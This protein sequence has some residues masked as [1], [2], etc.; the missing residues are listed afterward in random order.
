M[1]SG[2]DESSI[3]GDPEGR[4]LARHR[5]DLLAEANRISRALRVLIARADAPTDLIDA[6]VQELDKRET[7]ELLRAHGRIEPRGRYNT[8][9]PHPLLDGR[10]SCTLFV[11][12]SGRS[13][14]GSPGTASVFALAGILLD[15]DKI[16]EYRTQA[17]EIK[18]E[19]FGRTNFSFH[20][21]H[22]RNRTQDSK[23]RI[24]YS[25]SRNEARQLAFDAA[26]ENLI[27]STPFTAVGIGIRKDV[28]VR[29]FV[30]AGLDPYLPVKAYPLAVV[31]LLERLIDYLASS[32]P[33]RMARVIFESQGAREDAEHQLEYARILLE[34]SQWVPQR[35]FQYYLRTGLGFAPK[36]QSD[37]AEL[38]DFFS[39]DVFEWT[40]SGCI[41]EPKWWRAFCPKL[42]VRGDGGRGKFSL[43]VFPD[44]DIREQILAHRRTWGAE[45]S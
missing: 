19:F 15:D 4:R 13:D 7:S 9:S 45:G 11:D 28:F 40:R 23:S 14:L 21:P 5:A 18:T 20:E 43:K 10:P 42:H 12:E 44:S 37:P 17:D 35:A 29:D 39:R 25:F 1:A 22:M 38:A 8:P 33:A 36:G 2:R 34:G 6:L 32:P 24:D 30:D 26:I 16:D 3:I 41:D 31:F 27:F